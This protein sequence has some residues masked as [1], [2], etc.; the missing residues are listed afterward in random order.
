VAAHT[1]IP[2]YEIM[3]RFDNR[4]LLVGT[5]MLQSY[6]GGRASALAIQGGRFTAYYAQSDKA[7]LRSGPGA[8]VPSRSNSPGGGDH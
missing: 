6:F 5:G 4:V 7:E 1:V 3:T 8:A 2:K